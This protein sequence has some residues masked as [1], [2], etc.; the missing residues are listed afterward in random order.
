MSVATASIA[1][2]Q[3]RPGK[4][5]ISGVHK[6]FETE[7]QTVSALTPVTM[8]INEG[9]F[10]VFVGPSGCGKTTLLNIIAGFIAPTSGTILLDGKEVRGPGPDRL[11]MFQEPALFPW[12]S[13]IDNVCFGLKRNWLHHGARK[14]RARELLKTIHL[15]KFEN[16]SIHELSGGMKQRVALARALAPN[17]AVLLIDEPFNALDA[18]VKLELYSELQRIHQESGKTIIFVT[19]S[20]Q[21]AACLGDRVLVLSG[22]PGKIT[23]ELKIDLPRPRDFN[24]PKVIQLAAELMGRLQENQDNEKKS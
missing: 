12:L 4:L 5:E 24:D 13:V 11:M 14:E 17:P 19:H 21:E 6:S 10:V 15:E 16:A 3:N 1:P 22:S 23:H 2:T 8:E 20:M 18:V 9:E 7:S